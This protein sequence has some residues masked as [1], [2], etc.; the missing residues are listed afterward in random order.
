MLHKCTINHDHRLYCSWDMARDRC[1]C[2]FSYCTIFCPFA[3][4]H[5][6]ARKMKK[7]P[8]DIIMLH[9]C[10]KA[11]HHML[12]CSWDLVCDRCN[13]YFSFWVIFC[14]FT[15]PSC[16]KN[17]FKKWKKCLEISPFYISVPKIM[18][19][20]YTVLEIWCMMDII[21]VFHFGQFFDL[22][23]FPPTSPKNENACRYYHFT[24]EYQNSWSNAILL[25]RY[26]AWQ[27]QLL[28][29]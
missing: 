4:P 10:T 14:P 6:T 28:F 17:N 12:Y 5:L 16:L 27:M 19:I 8:G 1:S 15:P 29:I 24:Q 3:P 22:L 25:L 18:I 11:H 23:S 13:C 2:Y 20:C 21:V 9:K 26:G 7:T